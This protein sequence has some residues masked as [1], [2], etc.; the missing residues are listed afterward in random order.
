MNKD[1]QAL[2]DNEKD[3]IEIIVIVAKHN[4]HLFQEYIANGLEPAAALELTKATGVK[5]TGGQ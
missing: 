1:I 5:L 4:A 3:L 2:K